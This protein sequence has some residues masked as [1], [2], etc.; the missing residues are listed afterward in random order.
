MNDRRSSR[1]SSSSVQTPSTGRLD[2]VEELTDR[3]P[4][5]LP[6]QRLLTA[7]SPRT[8]CQRGRFLDNFSSDPD[9][10]VVLRTKSWFT[11][12]T[13]WIEVTQHSCQLSCLRSLIAS[14]RVIKALEETFS[15]FRVEREGSIRS[16]DL[17]ASIVTLCKFIKHE[18]EEKK[19][20]AKVKIVWLILECKKGRLYHGMIMT[21]VR[22]NLTNPCMPMICEDI[23]S[24][25]V[26]FFWKKIIIHV[27]CKNVIVMK[28]IESI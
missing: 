2:P 15:S 7:A 21:F 20:I 3:D 9:K 11:E 23:T 28:F 27:L 10:P 12:F 22:W 17:T 14:S 19:I 6:P 18:T 5:E 24:S 25:T 1:H 13:V 8:A 4:P 26:K 16:I